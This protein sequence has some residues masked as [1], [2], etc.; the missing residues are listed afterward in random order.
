MIAG[1][2]REIKPEQVECDIKVEVKFVA[3][4]K[5]SPLDFYFVPA[6]K[7]TPRRTAEQRKRLAGQLEVIEKWVKRKFGRK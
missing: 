2:L 3:K 6:E 5:G 7:P 1:R 4:P